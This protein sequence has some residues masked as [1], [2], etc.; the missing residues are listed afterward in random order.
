MTYDDQEQSSIMI[1]LE[2]F[3]YQTKQ[4]QVQHRAWK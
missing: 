2:G 3:M 1:R 4:Y